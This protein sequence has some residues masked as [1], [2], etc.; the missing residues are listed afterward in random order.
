MPNSSWQT[1]ALTSNTWLAVEVPGQK[2]S[3]RFWRSR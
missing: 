1:L 3:E 2:K